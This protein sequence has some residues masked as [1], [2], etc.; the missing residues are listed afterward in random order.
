MISLIFIQFLVSGETLEVEVSELTQGL[1]VRYLIII[2]TLRH[3]RLCL[4]RVPSKL[5]GYSP[6]HHRARLK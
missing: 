2:T 1:N 3:Q 6:R 5:V 4:N